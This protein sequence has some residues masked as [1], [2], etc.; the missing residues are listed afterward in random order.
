MIVKHI[1]QNIFFNL[2][3]SDPKCETCG[4]EP[5]QQSR[6]PAGGS[7][8][9]PVPTHCNQLNPTIPSDVWSLLEPTEFWNHAFHSK[10]IDTMGESSLPT[11]SIT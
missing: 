5:P 6:E 9:A 10:A 1:Y 3:Y 11:E 2:C 4:A 8:A 7:R